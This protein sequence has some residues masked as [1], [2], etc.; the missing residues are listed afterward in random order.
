MSTF[1]KYFIVNNPW[2]FF[3]FT[4]SVILIPTILILNKNKVPIKEVDKYPVGFYNDQIILIYTGEQNT[5][6]GIRGWKVRERYQTDLIKDGFLIE[7]DNDYRF[8]TTIII[9]LVLFGVCIGLNIIIGMVE[10]TG[11]DDGG[12]CN[13]EKVYTDYYYTKVRYSHDGN[14]YYFFIGDRL[15]NTSSNLKFDGYFELKQY[16]KNKNLLQYWEG[17]TQEVREKKLN[18]L[19][20]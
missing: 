6:Q 16:Y 19:L 17:T 20:K 15:L 10:L 13:L 2:K 9:L 5:S 7:V 3:L 4:V 8:S 14:K 1:I 11:G 12:F 18:Q